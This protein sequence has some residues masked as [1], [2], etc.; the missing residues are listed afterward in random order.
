MATTLYS[1]SS[2]GGRGEMGSSQQI[3]KEALPPLPAALRGSG[4]PRAPPQDP[5][6]TAPDFFRFPVRLAAQT[7]G[8]LAGPPPSSRGT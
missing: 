7:S 6:P 4:R 2:E 5:G 8:L 1:R 3:G